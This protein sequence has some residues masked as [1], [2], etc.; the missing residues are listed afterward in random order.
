MGSLVAWGA[1][2]GAGKGLSAAGEEAQRQVGQEKHDTRQVQLQRQRDNA[3]LDRQDQADRSAKERL[4]AEWG[5]GGFRERMETVKAG[6]A[7][8]TREDEQQHTTALELM[9]QKEQTARTRIT[10]GE[11]EFEWTETDASETRDPFTGAVETI[12]AGTYVRDFGG[13]YKQTGSP[14]GPIFIPEGEGTIPPDSRDI[15]T[16]MSRIQLEFLL[17]A[18]DRETQLSRKYL[19]LKQFKFLPAQYFDTYDPMRG[20]AGRTRETTT[21]TQPANQ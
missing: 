20:Q 11:S 18:P 4:Q 3:A 1:L 14:Q 9:K 5:E 6:I 2:G 12:E 19:Y 21:T 15:E 17:T 16:G 13:K 10:A 8:T 7:T